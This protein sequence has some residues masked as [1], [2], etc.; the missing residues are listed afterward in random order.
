LLAEVQKILDD[1]A[2]AAVN[3]RAA[4]G[5]GRAFELLLMTR[6]AVEL[7]SRGYSIYL[8]RSDG[9]KQISGSANVTFFQ[10]GGIPSGVQPAASG[11]SGPT[12]IVFQRS[13]GWSE[14]EIWNGIEFVGRSG[15]THEFD[16]AIV[17]K[18]LGDRLRATGGR[19]FGHG[20]L[21]LECKDVSASGDPDEM[22]AF[23]ARIYDTTL[24]KM[25]AP[26]LGGGV[27]NL[28]KIHPLDPVEPGFGV[29]SN[30]FRTENQ[31]AYH[32]IARRTGFTQGTA[33]MSNY[34]FI[35]RFDNISVGG[36]N[37]Q[38]FGQEIAN[39]IDLNL[40]ASV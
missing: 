26:Y 2:N 18:A 17:P 23:V 12:S 4:G 35:R 6:I 27:T 34:Y 28:R 19:P 7:K 16:L 32:G 38:Q 40:P 39:W 36:T 14:W 30:T 3:L 8:L 21:S 33:S 25:H 10:R 15:G 24:L 13:T 1:L 31:T 29:A 37:L 11:A 20:W 9:S 5:A 22:R